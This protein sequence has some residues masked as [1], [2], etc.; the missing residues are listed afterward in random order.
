MY[1][2]V[3]SFATGNFSNEIDFDFMYIVYHLLLCGIPK[4]LLFPLLAIYILTIIILFYYYA[5]CMF[6]ILNTT[7]SV[8]NCVWHLLFTLFKKCHIRNGHIHVLGYRI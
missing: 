5:L 6:P 3:D 2:L 1:E 4:I 7:S 8:T